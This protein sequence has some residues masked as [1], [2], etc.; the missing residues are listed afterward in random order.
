MW[1]LC[2]VDTL[3]ARGR[4]SVHQTS[5]RTLLRAEHVPLLVKATWCRPVGNVNVN[6][7][8]ASGVVSSNFIWN[9]LSKSPHGSMALRLCGRLLRDAAVLSRRVVASA[10]QESA[11]WLLTAGQS[12]TRFYFHLTARKRSL[13][14]VTHQAAQHGETVGFSSGAH[15]DGVRAAEQIRAPL[16]SSDTQTVCTGAEM[17]GAVLQFPQ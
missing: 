16:R 4:C 9:P 8:L 7:R 3:V 15:T 12:Q 13:G 11:S 5:A 6:K 1:E 2:V 17:C 14:A 10:R